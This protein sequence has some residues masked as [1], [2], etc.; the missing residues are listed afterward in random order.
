MQCWCKLPNAVQ[1]ANCCAPSKQDCDNSLLHTPSRPNCSSAQCTSK[2]LNNFYG[3]A[4][5]VFLSGGNRFCLLPQTNHPPTQPNPHP[6]LTP[7]F[8]PLLLG[9]HHSHSLVHQF[10]PLRSTSLPTSP[11]PYSPT[12]A[13]CTDQVI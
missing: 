3:S 10:P 8:P 4:C 11:H 7:L 5:R 12:K 2:C 6:V 1:K 9:P 13:K